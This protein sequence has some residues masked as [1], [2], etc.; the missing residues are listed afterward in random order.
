MPATLAAAVRGLLPLL[1][2]SILAGCGAKADEQSGPPPVM[3]VT[4][5]AP[6][7]QEVVDWDDYVG[8]FEAIQNV[9]VKPRATGYL[10]AVHF[11]DGQYVRAGQLLFTIDPRPSQAALALAQA[12][13]ARAQ[14]TLAN[15]RTEAA[16]SRA[17][18]AQQA[19][20]TEEVEQRQAAVRTGQADVAAAQASIRAQQLGVGFTRVLAPISGRIS[21]RR[22]DSGNSVTADQ[23]VLTTI[24]STDPIHFA[25][26]GAE[27][28][29]LKN[30]RLSGVGGAGT[31]V[32]V[33]L[34]D[35]ATYTHAG[36]IDFVDT[37]VGAGSGTV[38]ARAVV[39]N[40]DGFIKPGMYGQ[41]RVVAS[42]RYRALLVPDT[43]IV[44]DAAR[45][46]VY[47]VDRQGTVLA[48]PVELGP[49]VGSLRVVRSGLAP[50]E[51]VIING[52]Q[53][54]RPGQKVK[55]M[56]GVIRASDG[57]EPAPAAPSLAPAS[58]ATPAA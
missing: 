19:A 35:E 51:R 26:E 33:R 10:Q 32:R 44:T 20:S 29:L 55:P 38:R 28:L 41:A 7:V 39:A 1:L 21:E 48:R 47:V 34:Q 31:A 2:A 5:A 46:V 52:I 18:A 3:P 36:K 27:S 49:L 4:V 8:R 11:T 43:A 56:N 40:P 58:V 17:L 9:E 13:L 45:R 57:P 14:A 50:Q 16:R 22:V 54:A 53:R 15:A 12:Q 6:L 25:F 37:S 24:V 23:T 42:Q 30:Q